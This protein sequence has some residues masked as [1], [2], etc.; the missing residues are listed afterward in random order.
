MSYQSLFKITVRHVFFSTNSG[1]CFE[2]VPTSR[3]GHI[4]KNA[5]L[6]FRAEADRF[7]VAYDLDAAEALRLFILGDNNNLDFKFN[8]YARDPYF[9]NY[10]DVSSDPSGSIPCFNN[11]L[12]VTE[13][14]AGRHLEMIDHVVAGESSGLDDISHRASLARKPA[15]RVTIGVSG[16][17]L[18]AV[19]G[20]DRAEQGE[21]VIRFAARKTYWKYYLLGAFAEKAAHGD[22]QIRIIDQRGDIQFHAA[23]LQTPF[24]GTAAAVFY[25]NEPIALR[26]R[27]DN[28]FQLRQQVSGGEKVLVKRLANASAVN[29]YREVVNGKEAYVSEIY[30]NY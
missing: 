25:S 27:P 10:T 8:V 22:K 28:R 4:I 16:Q 12:K 1:P 23:G 17:W 2:F 30:V 21:Y 3:T 7:M 18:D 15:F 20:Q 6:L 13:T 19:P 29:L 11:R 5:D 26:E 9:A 24:T 14:A